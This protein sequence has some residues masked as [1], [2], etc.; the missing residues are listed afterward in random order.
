MAYSTFR[1]DLGAEPKGF[2]RLS[3]KSI[4]LTVMDGN[5]N[6]ALTGH[7]HPNKYPSDEKRS[8]TPYSGISKTIIWDSPLS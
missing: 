4:I 8:E 6:G 1:E 3:E 7:S 2:R 5:R